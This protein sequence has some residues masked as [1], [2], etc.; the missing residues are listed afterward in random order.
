MIW[1]VA[2]EVAVLDQAGGAVTAVEDDFFVLAH[3][4]GCVSATER[5]VVKI[6][7]YV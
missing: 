6:V 4:L 7:R 1:V 5:E 3:A 2:G